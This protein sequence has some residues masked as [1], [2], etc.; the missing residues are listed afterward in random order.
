MSL[1]TAYNPLP[2]SFTHG[3]GMWL[4]DHT[5]SAYLDS[6][7]GI[8]VCGLGHAH[9][10]VVQAMQEQAAKL[11][12]T[13]NAFNIDEELALAEKLTLMT[14]MEQAFFCNSGSEAN[15]AAIK[16]ARLYGHKKGIATPAIIVMEKAFHGRTLATLSASGSRRVQA[17]F[18]PLVPGFIRA[19][20]NDIESIRTIAKHCTDIVGVMLEPIQGEGGVYVADETYLQLLAEFCIEQDWLLMFDEVQTGNGRTGKLYASMGAN[21]QPDILTT[22]KGLANG[23]P[24]GGCLMRG[25]AADLFK[26]GSHGS[27]F[28]GNPFACKTALTVLNIIERDNLC[29]HVAQQGIIFKDRLLEELGA[30]PHVRAIRGKGFMLGIELD[31]PAQEIKYLALDQHLLLN[32]TSENVIRLLPALI[33]Q[34]EEREEL[35]RRLVEVINQ[36]TKS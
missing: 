23:V 22:A 9:P 17:G 12:H 5:G 3:Q 28:G 35:I 36:F 7:S 8:G 15:E 20:L 6:Y 19:P 21:V 29:K 16:L 13:S 2:I 1:I 31:R 34:E 27:T 26:P 4:Y 10:E 32:V 25:R 30:H 14:G 33:M 11:V 24:I 18:E